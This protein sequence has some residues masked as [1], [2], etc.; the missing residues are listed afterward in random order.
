VSFLALV[1]LFVTLRWGP[2]DA[3]AP[4]RE[5]VLV[6]REM[7]FYID[8]RFDE[9]NPALTF[10]AGERVRLVLRNEEI[11][12]RHNFAVPAW[13]V[14]SEEINGKGTTRVEFVVPRESARPEYVC[15]PHVAMMRGTIEIQ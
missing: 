14:S 11:G 15:T 3:G 13:G 7:S 1:A 2:V 6:V 9:P 10:R 4:N 12:M 8:G 5:L